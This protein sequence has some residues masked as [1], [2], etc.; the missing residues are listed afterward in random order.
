MSLKKTYHYLYKTVCIISN[1]YYFGMHS[2]RNLEDGYVGSG[3]FLWNSIRKYG[4]ENHICEIL[5]FFETREDLAKRETEVVNEDL[6]KDPLCMNLKCGGRGGMHGL[7]TDIISK[8]AKAGSD[9]NI[10]KYLNDIKYNKKVRDQLRENVI[11]NHKF[12]KLFA[13]NWEGKNH[14]LETKD[15]IGEKNSIKQ[16]GSG[17]SQFGTIWITNGIENKKIKR[18]QS[19][20][21]GWF[22]GRVKNATVV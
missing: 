10:R 1:R 14:K 21:D 13:P 18:E 7:S 17:N 9:G 2:T 22:R 4:K 19:F 20:D 5:E 8:I 3:K 12:G 15:K 16:K 11:L 6:L